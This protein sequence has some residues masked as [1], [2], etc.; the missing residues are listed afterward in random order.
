MHL[1]FSLGVGVVG[2][3]AIGAAITSRTVRRPAFVAGTAV[4]AGLLNPYGA[5][6]YTIALEA[7]GAADIIQEWRHLGFTKLLD[8]LVILLV[9]AA[10]LC[11]ALSGRWRNLQTSLPI[12]ALTA[13]T[14]DAVRNAP[15]LVLLASA[16][17]AFGLSR[18]L[19]RRSSTRADTERRRMRRMALGHGAV[20]GVVIFVALTSFAVSSVRGARPEQYPIRA[21]AAIPSGCRLLN[22]YDQGGY[23]ADTR[24]PDVH[25]SEDGRMLEGTTS[26]LEQQHVLKTRGQ[27]RSW[28]DQ[29]HVD[30]V[31]AASVPQD[32]G[33]TAKRPVGFGKRLTRAGCC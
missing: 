32:R 9:V 3:T 30:C 20:A 14:F 27:W 33:G 5:R 25:V 13:L 12:V 18:V 28:L 8:I 23:I 17:V 19:D 7:H 2:L 6:A 26:L 21:V 22:E 24:W 1:A 31:L 16:E 10:G 15:F 29:H 4:V 11:L